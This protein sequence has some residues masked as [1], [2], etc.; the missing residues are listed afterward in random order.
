ML[1]PLAREASMTAL[2]EIDLSGGGMNSPL[3][4][5]AGLISILS[6][7]IPKFTGLLEFP[8]YGAGV[9]GP[10]MAA[11]QVEVLF[12]TGQCFEDVV[13]VQQAYVSPYFGRTRCDP[14]CVLESLTAEVEI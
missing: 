13:T 3:N 11:E 2:C 1:L 6:N 4:I 14:R 7:G 9:G 5:F 10:E 8:L 12:E